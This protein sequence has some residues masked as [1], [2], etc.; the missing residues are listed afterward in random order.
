MCLFAMS[1]PL[2]GPIYFMELKRSIVPHCSCWNA[3]LHRPAYT[4]IQSGHICVVWKIT[5]LFMVMYVKCVQGFCRRAECCVENSVIMRDFC[6]LGG[7][8]ASADQ[9]Y[10]APPPMFGCHNPAESCPNNPLLLRNYNRYVGFS[11]VR[12]PYPSPPCSSL[13]RSNKS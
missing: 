7:C 11:H 13:S 5:G 4:R 3:T 12:L 2:R 9:Q 8:C 6:D 1:E 10:P